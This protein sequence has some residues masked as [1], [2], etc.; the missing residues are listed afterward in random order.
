MSSFEVHKRLNANDQIGSGR[1]ICAQTRTSTHFPLHWHDYFEIE[2][3][4][5][6]NGTHILNGKTYSISQ[7]D[8][9]LLTPTDFHEI[10]AD[11]S[12]DLINISFDSEMLTE[13]QLLQITSSAFPKAF[14]F[15]D[16]AYVRLCMV[17]QLLQHE[18]T[19]NGGCTQPLC[20]YLLQCF[21]R[22]YTC[23]QPSTPS[24]SDV[25]SGMK[26]AILYLELHFREPITLSQLAE[27]AGFHPNYF[28]E[29]FRMFTGQTY[30]DR[31]NTLRIGY[32]R[33]LLANGLSVSN[34]CFASGYGSL[35]NFLVTFKK[36]CGMTP[37]AY[38]TSHSRQLK[39]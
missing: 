4:T 6:G 38:K 2:I 36:Y 26:R 33:T 8:A 29:L 21:V 34:V 15:D 9:Y 14:H 37:S 23:Q 27:L 31:L 5:G 1:H 11:S 19:I 7:G 16:E 13:Q 35:S 24:N 32:A 22:N 3:V 28:S 17:A 39:N 10:V 12:L 20:T 25:L 30:T 18:C